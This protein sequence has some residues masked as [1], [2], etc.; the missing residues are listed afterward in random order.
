[1]AAS[2]AAAIFTSVGISVW[3][4]RS[5]KSPLLFSALS[6]LAGNLMFVASYQLRSLPLLLGARLLNGLGSARTANRRYTADYVSKKDRTMASA[7]FVGCSNLGQALGPFL[8]LPLA[9]LPYMM[10]APPLHSSLRDTSRLRE[11]TTPLDAAPPHAPP[12]SLGWP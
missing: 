9:F 5:F 8:S 1:M 10:G 2:D 7:A 6:C 11:A 4:Q 3:T 12:Q